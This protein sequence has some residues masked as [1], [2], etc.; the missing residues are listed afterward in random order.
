[1]GIG[2][3]LSGIGYWG[4]VIGYSLLVIGYSLRGCCGAAALLGVKESRS[5]T[6]VLCPPLLI[7]CNRKLGALPRPITG[8]GGARFN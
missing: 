1:M 8:A 6:S 7:T 4:L 3:W 5:E 2:Y